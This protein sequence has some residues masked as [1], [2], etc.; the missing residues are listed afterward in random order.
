MHLELQH[1]P[2]PRRPVTDP[3]LPQHPHD[4]AL[5]PPL[6]RRR[7]PA[8]ARPPTYHPLPAARARDAGARP[9][10]AREPDS[11][12]GYPEVP[13]REGGERSGDRGRAVGDRAGGG[14]GRV[15]GGGGAGGGR[16]WGGEGGGE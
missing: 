4:R 8:Q 11:S 13:D 1:H 16:G 6:R 9:D 3:V 2:R 15:G 7:L 14:A 12:F 10:G 5:A